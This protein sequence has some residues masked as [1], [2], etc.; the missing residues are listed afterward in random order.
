M[1]KYNPEIFT[2]IVKAGKRTYYFDV[3]PTKNTAELYI[4]ITEKKRNETDI[5]KFKIFLYKEDFDKFLNALQE[6]IDF[7]RKHSNKNES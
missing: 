7:A 2:K 5:E 6:S 1:E 4:T 3:R